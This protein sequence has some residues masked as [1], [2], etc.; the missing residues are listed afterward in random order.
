MALSMQDLAQLSRPES[1][2]LVT[3]RVNPAPAMVKTRPIKIAVARFILQKR[4][5]VLILKF[6]AGSLL[7]PCYSVIENKNCANPQLKKSVLHF[8]LL[9]LVYIVGLGIVVRL[10]LLF[11]VGFSLEYSVI[12][13]AK[14][15]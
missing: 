5:D 11:V 9:V 7:D 13:A 14:R 10:V 4:S 1:D 3:S 15:I 8:R 12:S 6:V 2:V